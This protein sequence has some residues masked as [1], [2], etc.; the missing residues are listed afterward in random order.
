MH[1]CCNK[2]SVCTKPNI[3][4]IIIHAV[5]HYSS[6]DICGTMFIHMFALMRVTEGRR[7]QRK[8]KQLTY[9]NSS[10]HSRRGADCRS[11]YAS[12]CACLRIFNFA[13]SFIGMKHLTTRAVYW[14]SQIFPRPPSTVI[15]WYTASTCP[16][17]RCD[18]CNLTYIH[19]SQHLTQRV[20]LKSRL[21]TLLL[22]QSRPPLP[23]MQS[24]TNQHCIYSWCLLLYFMLVK[25]M[26][27]NCKSHLVPSNFLL[28][29]A[30]NCRLLHS[31]LS[32]GCKSPL[33]SI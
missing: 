31:L 22:P 26:G 5:Y 11:I 12:L 9:L 1:V 4:T 14:A 8:L 18:W 6:T 27:P 13:Q 20:A 10:V 30:P 21:T 23:P 32:A 28:R 15:I 16:F 33:N 3:I 7:E 24:S 19:T 29:M 25:Q 2:N 17:H